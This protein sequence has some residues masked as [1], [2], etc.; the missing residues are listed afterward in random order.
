MKKQII[1]ATLAAMLSPN[2]IRLQFLVNM[3]TVF[4]R[5]K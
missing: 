1:R 2:P 4:R 5:R 3:F